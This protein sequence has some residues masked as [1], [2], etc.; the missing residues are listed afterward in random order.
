MKKFN[1][2]DYTAA[3]LEY[4]QTKISQRALAK[5]HKFSETNIA[6]WSKEE[7][8]VGERQRF[9]RKVEAKVLE[10]GAKK[11]AETIAQMHARHAKYGQILGIKGVEAIFGSKEKGLAPA[12]AISN[13]EDA[14]QAI[15]DGVMIERTARV[16]DNNPLGQMLKDMVEAWKDKIKN[17]P[18]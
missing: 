17:G 2:K 16:E 14:R 10:K 15:K 9:L 4:I 3:K 18:E 8:W 11:Q 13:F 1:H 12:V 6:R 7:D 5:K